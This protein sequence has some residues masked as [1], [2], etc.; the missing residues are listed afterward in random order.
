MNRNSI[1]NKNRACVLNRK[2][3]NIMEHV[4]KRIDTSRNNK[5]F[6]QMNIAFS[7]MNENNLNHQEMFRLANVGFYVVS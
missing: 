5:R 2:L 7:R 1:A 6:R 3:K 4:S